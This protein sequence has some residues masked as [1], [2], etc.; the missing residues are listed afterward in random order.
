MEYVEG[1]LAPVPRGET[2]TVVAGEGKYPP[3]VSSGPSATA[4]F[5]IDHRYFGEET[6]S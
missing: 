5:Q 2:E 3:F 6:V 1:K 4:G